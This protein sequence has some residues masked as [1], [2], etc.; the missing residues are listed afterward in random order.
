MDGGWN[1]KRS[2][3]LPQGRMYNA[4]AHAHPERTAYRMGRG[5]FSDVEFKVWTS[6][7]AMLTA[8]AMSERGAELGTPRWRPLVAECVK[9]EGGAA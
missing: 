3:Y 9:A 2:Y 6:R 5:V 7:A 4:G 8:C 1:V